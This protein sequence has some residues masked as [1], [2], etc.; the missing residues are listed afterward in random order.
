MARWEE[1]VASL[2]NAA[3]CL[4]RMYD[5]ECTHQDV[6]QHSGHYDRREQLTSWEYLGRRVC[7]TS[8]SLDYLACMR[9]SIYTSGAVLQTMQTTQ[10]HWSAQ[11]TVLLGGP[12]PNFNTRSFKYVPTGKVG[13]KCG[14]AGINLAWVQHRAL[15]EIAPRRQP[16]RYDHAPIGSY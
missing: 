6:S 5:K 14:F 10:I 7:W 13:K 1:K 9:L 15:A 8:W 12:S 16:S 4:R 11:F 3:A 2:H